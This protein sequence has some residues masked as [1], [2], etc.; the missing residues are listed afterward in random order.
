VKALFLHGGLGAAPLMTDSHDALYRAICAHP[1]EDT[2]R[3][4]FAD[5]VEED[6][7]HLRARFIRTQVAL[8]RVPPYDPAWVNARQHEPD[9]AT[10]WTLTDTLPKPLPAGASWQRFEFRRGFPWKVGVLALGALI[11]CGEAVFE[12][13]P[14]QALDIDANVRPDLGALAEWPHLARMH[15]LEFS[16]GWLGASD[17]ARFVDTSHATA[18][19]ELG[20]EFDGIAPD[21]LTALAGST[22][23]ARLHGLELRSNNMPSAL[24]VDSLAAAREPV[25]LSRLSLPF[26]RVGRDDAEHLFALPVMRD[27]EHLDVSDNPLGVEGVTALAESGAVHGLRILNLSKTRPGV[28]GVKALVEVGGLAGLRMLDL[29]DNLLGPVAVKALAGCDGLRGLRVLNLSS[30]LVGDSG[31]SALANARSLTG[32]LELDLR[33][34]DVTDAGALALAESPYL[35]G[36]LRLD[37]RNRDNR[38]L[39]PVARAALAE[40]FGEKVCL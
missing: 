35:D 2:P 18:L 34:A 10:G 19:T 40:R 27:L 30:N 14:I 32:L 25:S 3:L 31:A 11:E 1:D 12:A 28:P 13:A 38:E 17:V 39:G 16:S 37:L 24:L 8:A 21:G 20:F 9:A 23:F 5:L 29:S 22:L 15:K 7:D 26:N 33:D 36:L 4:A 6:G